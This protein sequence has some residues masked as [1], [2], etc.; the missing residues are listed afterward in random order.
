[1]PTGA[2]RELY[3]RIGKDFDI[4]T[5]TNCRMGMMSW[6]LLP[7]CYIAKQ[8]EATKSVSNS[9]LVSVALMEIYVFKFFLYALHLS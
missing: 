3:P 1:M 5:W 8:L 6:A 9:L 7:L 2:G 4:K